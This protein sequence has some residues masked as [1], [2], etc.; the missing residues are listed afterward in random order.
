MR[1]FPF[2]NEGNEVVFSIDFHAN[3]MTHSVN[4]IFFTSYCIALPCLCGC[5]YNVLIYITYLQDLAM[6][7]LVLYLSANH[8]ICVHLIITLLNISYLN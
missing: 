6:S 1:Y 2:T 5:S 8:N 4:T 7:P 3:T